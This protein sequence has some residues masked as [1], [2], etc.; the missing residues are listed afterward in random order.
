MFFYDGV[1]LVSAV[2]FSNRCATSLAMAAHARRTLEDNI[3]L[4][5]IPVNNVVASVNLHTVEIIESFSGVTLVDTCVNKTENKDLIV[6][7]DEEFYLVRAYEDTRMLR[8]LRPNWYSC[9]NIPKRCVVPFT[10]IIFKFYY[11]SGFPGL[12]HI[13][14]LPRFMKQLLRQHWISQCIFTSVRLM[15]WNLQLPRLLHQF[16][17]LIRLPPRPLI[18]FHLIQPDPNLPTF[19]S[20]GYTKRHV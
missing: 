3:K 6:E 20:C 10:T 1:G 16:P 17:S 7:H 4:K 11:F 19:L 9:Y 8:H 13:C 14:A 2:L 5:T 12:N 18:L 15:L